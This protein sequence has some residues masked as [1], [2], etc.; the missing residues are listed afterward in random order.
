MYDFHY[1]FMKEM[2]VDDIRLLLTDTDSL[3]YEIETPDLEGD[4]ARHR[5][6]FDLSNYSVNHSLNDDANKKV[7]LQFKNESAGNVI[8]A[9]LFFFIY[10]YIKYLNLKLSFT[11]VFNI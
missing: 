3:M 1:N 6:L 2:Y 7:V 9:F 5:D 8:I 11:H 10:I 4:M